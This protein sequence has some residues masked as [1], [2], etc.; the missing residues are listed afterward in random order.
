MQLDEIKSR[1]GS[2]LLSFPITDFGADGEFDR[3]S[4]ARRL[5]WLSSYEAAGLFAAGGTGEF[6]SIGYDEY[7]SII[8][9]AVA[10]SSA[11]VPVLA[12]VGYGTRMAVDLAKRAEKAGAAGILVLP[13]YLMFAEQEGIVAHM[14]AI[15]DAV[16]IG[17]IYYARDNSRLTPD[18]LARL[19][20]LCPN[21]VGYKDGI[22]DLQLMQRV[23]HALGDRLVHIGGLPT[24]EVFAQPYLE[25]G[26]TT[27]SSAVFN[28][29]PELALRFYRAV[30]QRDG[31]TIRSLMDSFY[32]PLIALRDRRRGYAVSMIK[33][34]ADLVGRPAGKVR[35]PLTDLDG[36]EREVLR[37][38]IAAHA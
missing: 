31:E 17:V 34:G 3:D 7:D 12:G 1:I 24:A 22:G 27:Y 10:N 37:Q 23:S 28:F 11:E 16:G 13:H 14:K 25:M 20:E 38:L 2:G 32:L 26:V 29:V 18:S 4:Y 19:A 21:L 8:E 6:F 15:C 36:E 9:T 30:R 33:A 5:Q 35:S